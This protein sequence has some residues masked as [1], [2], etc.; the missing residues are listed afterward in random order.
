MTPETQTLILT[1]TFGTL[2]IIG[3]YALLLVPFLVIWN[4]LHSK[5]MPEINTCTRRHFC[6]KN[7]EQGP[8]NGWPREN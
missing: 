1:F 4:K 5:P 6:G 8:C 3:G 2:G 7:V